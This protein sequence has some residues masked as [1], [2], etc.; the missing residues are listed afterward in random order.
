MSLYLFLKTIHI[1]AATMFFGSGMA[2][3]FLKWHADRQGDLAQIVFAQR[4]IVRA[5][6]VFTVPSGVLLPA[7]GF[8]MAWLVGFP[9]WSGWIAWGIGLYILAGICWLPAAWLQIR[10]RDVASHALATSSSLPAEYA[11]WSR[12]WLILGFPAFI[13]SALVIYV[14]VSKTGW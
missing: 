7:T 3:A 6:W 2:S 12:I 9:M 14:M 8:W 10:M 1:I 13:A 4:A 5:D 11:R